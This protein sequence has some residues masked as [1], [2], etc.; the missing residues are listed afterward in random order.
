MAPSERKVVIFL[1]THNGAEFLT[2]QLQSY[3]D[4]THSNWELLVS[5]DGSTDRTVQIVEDFGKA[6]PQ[7]VSVRNGP[8]REF[9]RNFLA[10]VRLEGVDGDF[11]AFSDQDDIW[12]PEKLARAVEWLETIPADRP[13]LYFTRTALIGRHGALIGFSPLFSRSCSFPNALVQNIGGGNTMVFNRSAKAL[14][15][16]TPGDI[17]LVA[18]DW[19]AYQIVTGSGGVSRY[20]LW[21]S[22]KYRQHGN[23]LIGSNAGFSRRYTRLRGLMR[24]RFSAWNEVNVAA[25]NRMRSHLTHSNRATLDFFAEARQGRFPRGQYLLWRSGIYRQSVLETATLFV[26]SMLGRI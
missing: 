4:Q 26:G 3:R 16:E 1:A 9:W 22:T 10:M 11:F 7:K 13:A 23:N 5:D 14:L 25:L 12:M 24:G 17:T 21:P 2:E 19:W 18:H 6:L 15:A 20:D 8:G